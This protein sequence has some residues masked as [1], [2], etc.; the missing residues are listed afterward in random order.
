MLKIYTVFLQHKNLCVWIFLSWYKIKLKSII[1]SDIYD[2]DSEGY[3]HRQMQSDW[4]HR[5]EPHRQF[6][7]DGRLHV[8][9]TRVTI[10]FCKKGRGSTSNRSINAVVLGRKELCQIW[11]LHPIVLLYFLLNFLFVLAGKKSKS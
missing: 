5:L 9:V 7:V 6:R 3:I 4:L 8:S 1:F 10:L 11:T 2:R